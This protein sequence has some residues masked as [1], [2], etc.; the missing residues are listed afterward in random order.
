MLINKMCREEVV[1]HII[2]EKCQFHSI[3]N[4]SIISTS[5]LSLSRLPP[6]HHKF[7]S[8]FLFSPPSLDHKVFLALFKFGINPYSDL[9]M[10]TLLT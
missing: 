8:F 9:T 4:K 2:N 3:K 1:I 7:S 5:T 10:T 6:Y